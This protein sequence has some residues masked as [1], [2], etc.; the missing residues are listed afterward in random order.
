MSRREIM[1]YHFFAY[2]NR[3]KYIRRWGL[4]RN[5]KIEND[6]EHV[7]QTAMIAH[8]IALL[9]NNRYERHYDAEH[10]AV[11]GMYHDASEVITGDLPTPIK[12]NNPAIKKEYHKLESIAQKRLLTMLPADIMPDYEPLIEPDESTEE[13]RIV[14]AADKISAY[15]KCTEERSAG[16]REFLQAEE[17]TLASIRKIDL[18]EVQ[19]FMDEFVPGFSMS[20][21]E[22]SKG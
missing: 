15:I 1:A 21:D 3:M 14:K 20:L 8:A 17:T 9:G 18:P 6:M 12:H 19:D 5:T 2:M 11:L 22:I 16:N 7:F 4:M 13:W 10:I